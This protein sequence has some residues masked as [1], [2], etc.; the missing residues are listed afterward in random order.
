MTT[1]KNKDTNF[2][3][4]IQK[5][6]KQSFLSTLVVGKSWLSSAKH[7][8]KIANFIPSPLTVYSTLDFTYLVELAF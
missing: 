3:L 5:P 8:S 6:Y 1:V 7:S 4:L 2:N